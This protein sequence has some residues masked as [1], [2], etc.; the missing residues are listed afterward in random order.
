MAKR[1]RSWSASPRGSTVGRWM[2]SMSVL[3]S[4]VDVGWWLLRVQLDNE[5][6]AHLRVDLVPDRDGEHPNR[7]PVVGR[8]E[9]CRWAA[10]EGVLI[11]AD[12]DELASLVAQLDDVA[13]AHAGAR[14]GD[15]PPVHLDVA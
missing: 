13:L 3:G 14:D 15:A 8:L 9:P 4:C 5:L 6:L 10:V 2:M 12:D 1:W 11:V 7:V